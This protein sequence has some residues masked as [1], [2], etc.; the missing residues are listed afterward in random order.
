[1]NC[2]KSCDLFIFEHVALYVGAAVLV[3]RAENGLARWACL[4]EPL[5]CALHLGVPDRCF[6]AQTVRGR[7]SGEEYASMKRVRLGKGSSNQC[8]VI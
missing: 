4:L 8:T 1:M 7:V 3:Y 6:L 5:G 2:C